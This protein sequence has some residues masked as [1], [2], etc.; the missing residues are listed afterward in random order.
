MDVSHSRG[1]SGA[2]DSHRHLHKL[3]GLVICEIV[4]PEHVWYWF[5]GVIQI[6]EIPDKGYRFLISHLGY[7]ILTVAELYR[8]LW[9]VELF[10][11]D[12]GA[13][14]ENVRLCVI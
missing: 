10:F 9:N 13:C 3:K 6:Q 1:L 4:K 14:Q 12:S 8:E 11:P 7:E 5:V 2:S